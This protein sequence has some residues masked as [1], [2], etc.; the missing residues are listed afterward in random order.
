MRARSLLTI[1]AIA[2]TLLARPQSPLFDLGAVHEIRIGFEEADWR[3][4]LEDLYTE[5]QNGRLVGD[6][7]IDGTVLAGCGIRFK[8]Y[9]SYSAGRIKNPFNIDLNH[10]VSGQDY[11]GQKK[12]KLSN[13][14]QDP[15]F[16]REVLTYA[17]AREYMPASRASYANVFVNDT[18]Q[19]L[20][21]I[22]EDV[23][24][25]FL[26][27]H[28]GENDGSFFKGNPP[29]VDLTGDNCNLSDAPGADSAAY[30]GIYELQ[31]DAGWGHL[32]ELI[33]ALN[34]QP[35]RIDSVLNVDRALWM[36]ALNYALINF[37]SYVGYAQNYYLYRD[38]EGLW[39]TIPWDMNMS[40]GAF[41]LSDAST[42]W[43]GFSV[44]QAMSIDPLSHYNGVSVSERPLMRS[45]FE[46]P[47]HRRMYL[48]HIRAILEDQVAS[49]T[50]GQLGEQVRALIDPHVQADTN[51][52]YSYQGFLDNF[53]DQVS[54]TIAYPGLAQLMNGRIAYMQGVPGFT[55][56]PVISAPQHS[57]G[58]IGTGQQL[59]ITCA[60]SGCDTAFIAYR[61][62]S[63]G[64]FAKA[65]LLDD[66]AH[67]DGAAGDGTY[68]AVITAETNLIEY[69]IYAENAT[70]GEFS[71]RGAAYMTH[72]V[73]T[74]IEPG[75]LVINE[76]MADNRVQP[77]ASGAT[78]DWIE[79]F[80][81]GGSTISTAGLHLSDDAA[82]P[83]EWALP[84]FTLAPGEYLIIWADDRE[85]VDDYHA[86]FKLDAEGEA[87]LLAYDAE[88]IIDQV[89][90]GPQ[91]PIYSW[92]RSPNGTGGFTRMA[93]TFKGYNLVLPGYEVDAAFQIWP[94]PASSTV[95]AFIDRDGDYEVEVVRADGRRM[96]GPIKR[97]SRQLVE[98]DAYGLPSG[99]YTLRAV[100]SDAIL[101]KPFIII[102]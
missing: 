35:Q 43:N 69:Y 51:K 30:S 23:G 57:P 11:Q 74:R 13:V 67:G 66:G 68:G 99:H 81:A 2:A 62:G 76:L 87:L 90:F 54:F 44:N 55:G 16:L 83:Q 14:F 17:I 93:P 10:T 52:F 39:N 48:A 84:A 1:T 22:T 33:E 38:R 12:I 78:G 88:N 85:W 37:D 72:R 25:D 47:R 28:F 56:Q 60:I 5:G 9:S 71:P 26:R 100:F 42:Y 89:A 86:S 19:G 95:H 29:T 27:A 102:P 53:N 49:G 7:S 45:L 58:D 61:F 21:V 41:R 63:A 98:V 36:H 4:R 77:D 3:T 91:Y 65:A 94:N 32:L 46:A 80:N 15:S 101:S 64:R 40:F 82:D 6:V 79:L 96:L 31:S 50:A 8:G 18:L 70:A 20:Y 75:V 24:N 97:S 59:T 92:A 34:T 73:F